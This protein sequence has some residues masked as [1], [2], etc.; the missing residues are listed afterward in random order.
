MRK[1]HKQRDFEPFNAR[2]TTCN[3]SI[4]RLKGEEHLEFFSEFLLH[5]LLQERCFLLEKHDFDTFEVSYGTRDS[6][7]PRARNSTLSNSI[8]RFKSEEHLEFFSEFFLHALLQ[9][10]DL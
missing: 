3:V 8:D 10:N 6:G 7:P 9:R 4:D 1:R 5:T 2:I